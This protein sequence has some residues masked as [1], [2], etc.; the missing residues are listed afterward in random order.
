MWPMLQDV[1]SE[2]PLSLIRDKDTAKANLIKYLKRICR[3]RF[4]LLEFMKY[5]T[6]SISVADR[7]KAVC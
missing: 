7:S 6:S 1:I 3:P 5:M 2:C 4:S